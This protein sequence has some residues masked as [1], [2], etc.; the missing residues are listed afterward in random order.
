VLTTYEA[1]GR[2]SAELKRLVAGKADEAQLDAQ[3]LG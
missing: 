3:V 1:L 2:F